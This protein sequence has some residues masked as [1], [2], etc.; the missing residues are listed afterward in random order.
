MVL[1]RL[2]KLP[3][4][5][6][7]WL[8]Q[9]GC[10]EAD[11]R[12]IAKQGDITDIALA[13]D[14]V[15]KTSNPATQSKYLI[16]TF[17]LFAE[18]VLS[19]DLAEPP[20]V[21]PEDPEIT[22]AVAAILC[23]RFIEDPTERVRKWTSLLQ[24]VVRGANVIV[25]LSPSLAREP[26][27]LPEVVPP[28]QRQPITNV[29]NVNADPAGAAAARDQGD[30]TAQLLAQLI[31]T[32]GNGNVDAAEELSLLKKLANKLE[33]RS[34]ITDSDNEDSCNRSIL[35]RERLVSRIIER[36]RH[37]LYA[38]RAVYLTEDAFSTAWAMEE[39][40]LLSGG[41]PPPD[42]RDYLQNMMSA[43][44]RAH[45]TARD[46]LRGGSDAQ[47][48]R[49]LLCG[50]QFVADEFLGALLA[51]ACS[52]A[53]DARTAR[54]NLLK[55]LRE[56][57]AKERKKDDFLCDVDLC[58]AATRNGRRFSRGGRQ[59]TERRRGSAEPQTT[60]PAQ[61]PPPPQGG[62][63]SRQFSAQQTLSAQRQ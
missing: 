22:L 48:R 55:E 5:W 63:Q 50:L 45:T 2:S 54:R 42:E 16:R 35:R 28:A 27:P 60:S 20:D 8:E 13:T 1:I 39:T 9:L 41:R 6:R 46:A 4:P 24:K 38:H 53:Q 14:E 59:R 62:S 12:C 31:E 11:G 32:R 25:S 57:R 33:E 10:V 34:W 56:Q 52:D 17:S 23:K 7:T 21:L 30:R 47:H 51:A 19:S 15:L 26:E 43:L 3:T 61:P 37:H 40:A 44:L 36:R 58:I 18:S 29:P 49:R